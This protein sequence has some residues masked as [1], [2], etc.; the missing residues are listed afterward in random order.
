VTSLPDM[1]REMSLLAQEARDE[2]R[3]HIGGDHDLFDTF[4]FSIQRWHDQLEEIVN[5]AIEIHQRKGKP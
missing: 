2:A 1:I 3:L 4:C 5:K